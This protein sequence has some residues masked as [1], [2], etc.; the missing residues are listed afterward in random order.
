MSFELLK[1]PPIHDEL[2]S[3]RPIDAVCDYHYDIVRSMTYWTNKEAASEGQTATI[4]NTLFTQIAIPFF[5]QRD[6]L[7]T[8]RRVPDEISANLF[9]AFSLAHLLEQPFMETAVTPPGKPLDIEEATPE[10]IAQAAPYLID[11]GAATTRLHLN[12]EDI[13]EQVPDL[14]LPRRGQRPAW[15]RVE[16]SE[17]FLQVK[18]PAELTEIMRKTPGIEHFPIRDMVSIV[19]HLQARSNG[20]NHTCQVRQFPVFLDRKSPS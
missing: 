11:L 16:G 2:A 18:A 17:L 15:C 13:A 6:Y 10:T 5:R 19:P 9:G 14:P 20:R 12:R 4:A 7:V 8:N 3:K 1:K